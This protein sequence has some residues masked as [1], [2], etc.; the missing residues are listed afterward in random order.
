M[1]T[2]ETTA[3]YDLRIPAA[4][5]GDIFEIDDY[6]H[7]MNAIEDLLD[8]TTLT[9][10]F[11][12]GG[13]IARDDDTAVAIGRAFT[14]TAGDDGYHLRIGGTITEAGS[15][16]HAVVAGL[17]I[18]AFAL[19]N[20]GGATTSLA[21]LYIAGAPTGATPTNGPYAIY[22]AGGQSRFNST[23][24]LTDAID[25][26]F[27]LSADAIIRWS[28]GDA[29]NH[30]LV[31]GLDNTNQGLHITD[32]AAVATDWNISAT[33]H[34]N[35]YVHSNT[36]PATDYLRL[37]GHDGTT[38]YIDLVGGTNLDFQIAGT[39]E[40]E[41]TATILAPSTSDG[42]A[43]G[44]TSLM[45]G[46]LFLAS[47]GVAN[48]NNGDML[49]THSSNTLTVSGGTFATAALTASTITGSGVLSIDDTTAASST[50]SGSIHTDGG[51]GVAGDIYGGDDLALT[52]SGAVVNFNAGDMLITHSSNTLTV[53]GGTLAT[54]ALTAS[55][56][57]GSG[58]LSIDDT[59]E[60]TSTTSGSV[61]TDGGLGVA[62]DIY[63]GD[64]VFLS[65]GAVLNF[66][67]GDVT[68][69]HSSNALTVAGGTWATAALSAST[70]TGSGVLSVD[71]TTESTSTTSGSIHTDGGL[72]VA[73]DIYAGDDIF[74]T[75]G[76]VL[77]FNSGDVTVTHSSNTITVTGGIMA[78]DTASTIGN[79]TLGDGSI[80]DS[81]GAIGFGNENLSTTGTLSSGATTV[82]SLIMSDVTLSRGA[83]NRLDLA[84]GDDFRINEGRFYLV[85]NTNGAQTVNLEHTGD[86]ANGPL[87]TSTLNRATPADN[88]LGFIL[89]INMDDSGNTQRQTHRMRTVFNDVTSTTMDSSWEFT[90]MN[91]V[92]AS[93]FNTTATLTNAGVWTDASHEGAKRRGLSV[94]EM[95]PDFWGRFMRLDTRAYSSAYLPEGE[96]R[97]LHASP[98]AQQFYKEFGLGADPAKGNPGIAP[99]DLAGVSMIGVQKLRSEIQELKHEIKLLKA[100]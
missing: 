36:T 77:N 13:A 7:V 96:I 40:M 3:T 9:K 16:T 19:T 63:A 83:A 88:D 11:S 46:G 38:A 68:V 71:D 64:D 30:S 60:S 99:K 47:G 42:L 37:G 32:K 70:I 28:T 6:R 41:L 26:E 20:A 84:S 21:G 15:G 72:G 25:L 92:N 85:N 87:F 94:D 53:S 39:S 52:S 75:S 57:T 95:W 49:I 100:A 54:A 27:G 17:R 23:V 89:Q 18:D 22:V 34:P 33:T 5:G 61:H 43:L 90:T 58:V 50:T 35:L 24:L 55:T 56:I 1:S 66:N 4:A 51:L 10:T 8:G 86:G 45:W 98:G 12:F 73:G 62:G 59:T 93:N 31:I 78:L 14:P 67:S 29:D 76:A 79:L 2:S 97:D 69:T 74:F 48:F 44:S 80:T 82:T 65:S 81:S 91:A